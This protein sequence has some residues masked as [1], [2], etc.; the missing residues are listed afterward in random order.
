MTVWLMLLGFDILGDMGWIDN[1]PVELDVSVDAALNDFGDAIK[2][3]DDSQSATTYLLCAYSGTCTLHIPQSMDTGIFRALQTKTA[4]TA[5]NF[6][7]HNFLQVF[8]I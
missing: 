7:T 2:T 3:S 4:I 6:K 1:R 8:L 5:E